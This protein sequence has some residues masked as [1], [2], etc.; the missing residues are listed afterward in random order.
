MKIDHVLFEV[1]AD[2]LHSRKW[3]CQITEEEKMR[4]WRAERSVGESR[5]HDE[6]A[7]KAV[8]DEVFNNFHA[9]IM[10]EMNE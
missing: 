8:M 7:K 5:A 6:E 9:D 2:E 10:K 4:Y 1:M 3:V